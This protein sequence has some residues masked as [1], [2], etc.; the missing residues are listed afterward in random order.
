MGRPRM[1]DEQP[2]AQAISNLLN[3]ALR[4]GAPEMPVRARDDASASDQTIVIVHNGGTL[5]SRAIHESPF[6]PMVRGPDSNGSGYN[7]ALG[8]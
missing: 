5:N 3:N 6:V 2:M 8:F 1:C 4:H 7:L